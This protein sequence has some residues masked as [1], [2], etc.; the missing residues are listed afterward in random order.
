MNYSTLLTVARNKAKRLSGA[1]SIFAAMPFAAGAAGLLASATSASADVSETILHTFAGGT[2][3]SDPLCPL[4]QASD[5]SY[6]GTTSGGGDAKGDGTVF[7]IDPSGTYSVLYRFG[8][9]QNDGASPNGG[10]V[11]GS[12]GN[13]YGTTLA[14]GTSQYGT[15]Y[16]LTPT[17]TE[18][19]LHSFAGGTDGSGP[20]GEMVFGSDGLLYGTTYGND[21]SSADG[22]IFSLGTDGGDYAVQYSFASKP[23]VS[24]EHPLAGLTPDGSGKFYGTT[25]IGGA[26]NAG[27]VFLFTSGSPS[28]SLSLVH[29]YA[30]RSVHDDGQDGSYAPVVLDGQG[31]IY[32]TTSIGGNF[33][34]GTFYEITPSKTESIL[35]NFI[36]Q[37]D[38]ET[39]YG[40]VI[41]ANDGNFYGTLNGGGANGEGA[42]YQM[43]TQGTYT[44]V[45]D[46]TTATS[47][48]NAPF[49]GLLE[50]EDGSLLGTTPTG[51]SSNNGVIYKLQTELQ[52][53]ST[54]PALSHVTLST[55]TTTGGT[56]TFNNRVSLAGDATVDTSV[57]FTS[58]DPSVVSAYSEIIKRGYSSH[59]FAIN[60]GQVS[61]TTQVTITA[62]VAGVSKSAVLTVTP[63]SGVFKDMTLS[64][65]STEGGTTT[66]A[67]R[68][69]LH[70]DAYADTAV[71]ITS[72]NTA[73][74]QIV[75]SPVTIKKG[76]SSHTFT[77]KTSPVTSTQTVMISASAN[78]RGEAV[79]LTITP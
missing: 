74:A 37:E 78:G 17:G 76:S 33:A 48:G 31:D 73:L 77:I 42:V 21:S 19:V 59:T 62:M 23:T 39:P 18:T 34:E 27:T 44:S 67:N 14:G 13:L 57:T 40:G 30:D 68:V 49:R 16:K 32:G 75:S 38:G 29:S 12:D 15:V 4:I 47:D 71:A 79:T 26:N 66:T 28:G 5:G 20:I 63:S 41:F 45:Y 36:K 56:P 55:A 2:D 69:Y 43:T 58:S 8:A 50:D 9:S 25:S 72:S 10:L 3:G 52:D 7:K 35:H 6:Y 1:A 60:V 64:P 54:N 11:E 46:F 22:T 65:S 70:G 24:G 51:G 53:V 61:E